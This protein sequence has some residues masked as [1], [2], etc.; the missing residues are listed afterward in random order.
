VEQH[1][2]QAEQDLEVVGAVLNCFIKLR[3]IVMGDPAWAVFSYSQIQDR[4]LC[5]QN[6][7]YRPRGRFCR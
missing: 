3:G 6:P 7:S 5:L 2:Q 4:S 1:L